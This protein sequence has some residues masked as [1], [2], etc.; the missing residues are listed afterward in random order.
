MLLQDELIYQRELILATVDPDSKI[1]EEDENNNSLSRWLEPDVPLDV[2]VQ[3]ISAVGTKLGVIVL[4]NCEA[5]LRGVSVRI[6]VFPAGAQQGALS[7]SEHE[8]N[9]Q[10]SESTTL[11]ISDVLAFPG[12][13]FRVVMEALGVADANPA[14]N[15]FEGA[16]S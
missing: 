3:G 12:L 6:S 14:N 7:I 13:A 8:L 16:I 1:P 2:A 10:P 9:L 5:P 11:V 15:T 4:N